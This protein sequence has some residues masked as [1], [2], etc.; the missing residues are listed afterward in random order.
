MGSGIHSRAG[1]VQGAGAVYKEKKNDMR[2]FS[3][4]HVVR[5]RNSR[6][7]RRRGASSYTYTYT[8]SFSSFL[9][10]L[11]LFDFSLFLFSL[12]TNPPPSP[13]WLLAKMLSASN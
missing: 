5:A 8:G 1:V 12:Q 13:T 9:Y 2:N 10:L 3:W 11:S 4:L 6:R 7:G